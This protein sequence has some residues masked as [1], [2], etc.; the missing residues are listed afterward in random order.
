VNPR[1]IFR[2]MRRREPVQDRVARSRPNIAP[3]RFVS[4]KHSNGESQF[5]LV[6]QSY[7][8]SH[9]SSAESL[10]G[11]ALFHPIVLFCPAHYDVQ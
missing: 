1:Q 10:T 11:S 9:V 4:Q 2:L 3:V 7:R 8:D 6:V 5:F